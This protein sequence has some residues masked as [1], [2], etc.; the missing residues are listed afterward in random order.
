MLPWWFAK[1]RKIPAWQRC[2]RGVLNPTWWGKLSSNT[3]DEIPEV[4]LMEEILHQLRFVVCPIIYRVLYIRTSQVVS[5]ISSINS[6]TSWNHMKKCIFY[7]VSFRCKWRL[8]PASKSLIN[9]SDVYRWNAAGGPAI[10]NF[11]DHAY[12]GPWE[13]GPPDFPKLTPTKKFRNRNCWWRVRGIFHVY[14][15]E[16]LGSR[17]FCMLQSLKAHNQQLASKMDEHL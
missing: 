6:S 13:D 12:M 8:Q 2:G 17:L 16:I 7:C 9:H 1:A 11:S 3:V 15:G 14:V 4:L 10:R 5:R